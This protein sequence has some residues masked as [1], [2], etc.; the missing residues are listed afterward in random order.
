MR[1]LQIEEFIWVT[2]P[3]RD[4][5]VTHPCFAKDREEDFPKHV[6]ERVPSLREVQIVLKSSAEPEDQWKVIRVPRA[7][8]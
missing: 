6:L 5:L 3:D 1:P 4:E 2:S 8:S 7:P